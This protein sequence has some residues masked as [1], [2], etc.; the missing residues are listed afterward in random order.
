MVLGLSLPRPTA[1]HTPW[2]WDLLLPYLHTVGECIPQRLLSCFLVKWDSSIFW[3]FCIVYYNHISYLWYNFRVNRY[4]ELRIHQGNL[5]KF[6]TFLVSHKALI[7]CVVS[8]LITLTGGILFRT[9]LA[10]IPSKISSGFS[11]NGYK[12]LPD[13]PSASLSA[14]PVEEPSPSDSA[15]LGESTINSVPNISYTPLPSYSPLPNPTPIPDLSTNTTSST[16]SNSN[17][18]SGNPNCTSSSG[19][20]NSW[21]SDVYFG[22]SL[23]GSGSGSANV[24][25]SA[26]FSIA[27]RDCFKSLVSSDQISISS[28]N[29][30]VQI[31]PVS[32]QV[33]NG[34]ASFT[35]T[36]QTSTTA[37]LKVHDNNNGF[38]ITDSN[39]NSPS[40]IFGNSGTGGSSCAGIAT[41]ANSEVYTHPSSLTV[42][43]TSQIEVDLLDC[44]NNLISSPDTVDIKLLGGD[45]GVQVDGQSLSP[46]IS[47]S[48]SGGKVFF[49][50]TANVAV[51]YTFS[52]TDTS[53]NPRL[54]I[55]G[56]NY[57]TPSVTF[58][59][60]NSSPT[61]TPTVSPTSSPTVSPSV[62]PSPAAS[63][64]ATPSS[65][66]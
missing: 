42:G 37:V 51:Q 66:L 4:Q 28:S 7:L 57:S 59:A 50:V 10:S 52:I 14:L 40:V 29:P 5:G 22:S 65:S 26:T 11:I 18:S 56:P 45:S 53:K 9:H 6:K 27:I 38:D 47:K 1:T 21:Y 46:S 43:S 41:E 15:V 23:S 58:I 8:T 3:S 16:T 12:P 17:S 19:T 32:I 55:T 44:N 30:N 2:L 36:S 48:A 35:V 24:G 64:S 62:S 34:Q 49:S 61:S 63:S 20:P 54:N 25:S 33:S 60:N 13:F 31:S 39:N